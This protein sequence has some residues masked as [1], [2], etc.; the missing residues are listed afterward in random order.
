MYD[1]FLDDDCPSIVSDVEP[2]DGKEM[3]MIKIY[4]TVWYVMKQLEIILFFI[5]LFSRK[6]QRP[7]YPFFSMYSISL[8]Y[9]P[10]DEI[11]Q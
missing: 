9:V 5:Q 8:E 6:M 4:Y 7:D 3:D 1:W 10:G 2:I 11:P